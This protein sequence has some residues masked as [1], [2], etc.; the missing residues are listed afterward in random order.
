MSKCWLSRSKWAAMQPYCVERWGGF[1][2]QSRWERS[3]VSA[4]LTHIQRVWILM[5]QQRDES[6][7]QWVID[8]TW[9]SLLPVNSFWVMDKP[10][11]WSGPAGL[12][13]SVHAYVCAFT[14]SSTVSVCVCVCFVFKQT[15]GRTW[16]CVQVDELAVITNQSYVQ[17]LCKFH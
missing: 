6:R 4:S 11:L 5:S 17:R 16:T 13:L 9:I 7:A 3:E 15:H 10:G 8:H 1:A 12:C 2:R 14:C